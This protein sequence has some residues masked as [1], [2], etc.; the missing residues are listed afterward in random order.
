M[1]RDIEELLPKVIQYAPGCPDITAVDHL[2]DAAIQ[3]CERTRCWRVQDEFQTSGLE[4]EVFC[5][6]DCASLYQIEKAWFNE[7]ELE[8][9]SPHLDMLFHDCGQPRFISQVSPNSIRL[10]PF[11]RGTLHLSMYLKPSPNAEVLP[12]FL[13]DQFARALGDGALSTLLLLP[14][15]PFSNP[16]LGMAFAAKFE[17][18]LDKNFAFNLRGQQR[19]PVRTK[20]RY[21]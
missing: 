18:V 17:A 16:Q 6:P 20:P 15:Q 13:F 10:E 14:N 21:L 12:C 9:R 8:A 1:M 11:G 2:R 5:V 7:M 19:A 3:L 4:S